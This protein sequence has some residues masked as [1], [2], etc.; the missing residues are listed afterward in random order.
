MGELSFRTEDR[1]DGDATIKMMRRDWTGI[2]GRAAMVCLLSAW[3]PTAA[4][5]KIEHLGRPCRAKQVL[6]G[7]V[8][9]DRADGRER[10]VLLNDNES[11]GAEL[12]F[13]DF[14]K[15]TG[16]M[17]PAPAGAGGRLDRSRP[18]HISTASGRRA[19]TTAGPSEGT[20]R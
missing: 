13:I 4:A 10:F 17:I 14:E 9:V 5:A 16:R 7:R 8:V 19:L 3:V 20:A 12:L 1:T 2:L 6:A 15:N 11:H 18:T